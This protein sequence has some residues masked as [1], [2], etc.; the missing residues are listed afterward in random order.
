MGMAECVWS[1]DQSPFRQRHVWGQPTDRSERETKR[2]LLTDEV[3]IPLALVAAGANLHDVMVLVATL[4]GLVIARRVPDA[5]HTQ[6]LCL[7]AVFA[8]DSVHQAVRER[9]ATTTMVVVGKKR[10]RKYASLAQSLQSVG[11]LGKEDRELS[12]L[13][14]ASLRLTHL[15]ENPGF[16]IS[17]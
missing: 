5:E 1:D 16:R 10:Q 12:R 9:G 15:L 14:S 11:A 2:S 6:Y 3:R 8:T 17:S 7:D 13:S 4:E